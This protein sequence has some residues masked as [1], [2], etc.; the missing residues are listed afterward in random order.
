MQQMNIK[1]PCYLPISDYFYI[2][3]SRLFTLIIIYRVPNNPTRI[4]VI[5]PYPGSAPSQEDGSDNFPLPLVETYH[6]KYADRDVI[7]VINPIIPYF[8]CFG[9]VF[10]VA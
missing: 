5:E 9:T 6:T 7:I 8:A 2:N 4:I 3:Q 10:P 1:C